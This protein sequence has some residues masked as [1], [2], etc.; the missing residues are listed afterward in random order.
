[1]ARLFAAPEIAERVSTWAIPRLFP[2]ASGP[3]LPRRRAKLLLRRGTRRL[4]WGRWA[5]DGPRPRAIWEMSVAMYHCGI[6]ELSAKYPQGCGP[7]LIGATWLKRV[8]GGSA[9]AAGITS[10]P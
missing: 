3:S 1:M 2:S 8:P 9:A 5:G 10:A 6:P 7:I 4:Q